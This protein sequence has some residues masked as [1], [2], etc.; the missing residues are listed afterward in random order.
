MQRQKVIAVVGPTA[1][2][3]TALG[4]ELAR[5]LDGEV[6][7][8]DSRQVYSDMDIIAGV[9][10]MRE[11]RNVPHHLLRVASPKHVYSA[12]RFLREGT[13][14]MTQIAKR[15]RTPVIVGGTGFYTESLLGK[16]N[17]PEVQPNKK[18]RAELSGKTAAEMFEILQKI[19]PRRASEIDVQNPARLM[20]AIE[21]AQAL[22]AVPPLTESITAQNFD[23]LWLGIK[24]SMEKLEEKI[25]ARIASR[26]HKGA[27][28]ELQKL[29]AQI[30]AKRIKELGAEFSLLA[31]YVDK[32]ITRSELVEM[33]AK[34]EMKYVTRQLRWHKRNKDII[35]IS[36]AEEAL[37]LAQEFLKI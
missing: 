21:I 30:S 37:K 11:M 29:R 6:I 8:A 24:P 5:A 34:W 25:R 36:G 1:S 28:A 17:L 22:G 26:M 12:G 2:G 35:W 31:D 32:K 20:R 23:I 13:R 33:L 14:A 18:L 15:G 3:K 27:V 19:D 4:V 7:S 9:P 16:T 10:T